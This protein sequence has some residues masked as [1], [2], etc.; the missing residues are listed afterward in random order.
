MNNHQLPKITIIIAVFNS[1]K[2]LQQCIDSVTKQTYLNKQ[3]IIIDGGSSD[4]TV[5]LLKANSEKISYW[6]SE[7]D[8]GIYNAWNKGLEKANGDWI[9]FLGADDFFWNT[10]ILEQMSAQLKKLPIDI[11]VAYGKI[12]LLNIEAKPLYLVGESWDVVKEYFKQTMTIPH[13]G[14]MHRHSLFELH[15]KFD[16]S[17]LISGDYE[18]LLRELKNGNAAFFQD[19]IVAGMRQGGISS[20]PKQSLTS[21]YEVRRAQRKHGLRLPRRDWMLSLARVYI[22]LFLWQ[23]LG[24]K[25]TK[26]VLDFGRRIIGLPA[27]W[28]KI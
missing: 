27:H 6:I 24:E 14:L 12:M 18:L 10:Q 23:V 19:I 28:T 11:L 9:C 7:P 26:K 21:L 13:P 4:G 2:T 20:C 1:A 3:L 25:L 17:F 15:G 16:E 22:R 5:D 8:K